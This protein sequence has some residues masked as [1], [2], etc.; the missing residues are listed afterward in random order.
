[1]GLRFCVG[2]VLKNLTN[3]GME[4]RL[5]FHDLRISLQRKTMISSITKPGARTHHYDWSCS[6]LRRSSWSQSCS[7]LDS[8]N[9]DYPAWKDRTMKDAKRSDESEKSELPKSKKPTRDAKRSGVPRRRATGREMR[10]ATTT[11]KLPRAT[12]IILIGAAGG[13][14]ATHTATPRNLIARP[15]GIGRMSVLSRPLLP[16]RVSSAD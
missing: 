5:P 7:S 9:P 14:T 13:D 12:G 8:V 3:R 10:R 1:M 6:E 15:L 2:S 11:R 16:R 4:A